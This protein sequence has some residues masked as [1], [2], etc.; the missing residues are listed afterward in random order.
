MS[1]LAQMG[2]GERAAFDVVDADAAPAG[3]GAAVDEDDRD[4]LAQ[5]HVERR[6]VLVDRRDQHAAHALLQEQLEVVALPRFVAVAVADEDGDVVG[7][8]HL[9]DPLGHVGEERVGGV[10]H[11]VGD[12]AA[13]PEPQLAPDSLRTKPSSSIAWSTRSRV[14]AAT[15]SGRFR[16]FDTVPTETPARAATSLT[17][18]ELR[19]TERIQPRVSSQLRV[20]GRCSMVDSRDPTSISAAA[21]GTIDIGGDLTVNR[22]GFGAMR[23]TGR[24]I[25]GEPRDRE[26]GQGRA[27]P[28]RRARREPDRHRRLLRTGGQRDA[29]RRGPPPVPRRPRDR[30]QGRVRAARTRSV[31]AER[32]P[33]SPPRGVRGEPA[34]APARADPAVPAP[35]PRSEGR[36][37]TTRSARSSS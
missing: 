36:L 35:P 9:L 31:D 22:L 12:R 6:R 2:H 37:S 23:V 30:H 27:P 19:L 10:E 5:E 8:G 34:P 20:V 18:V 1:L 7:A 28:C 24:G 4:V 33:R 15:S 14:A 32:P 25:W 16:T 17:P 3:A 29:H 21:A 11:H 26:R 13:P